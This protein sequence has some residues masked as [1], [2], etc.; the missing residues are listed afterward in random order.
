MESNHLATT[1]LNKAYR[2]TA[3]NREQPPINTLF[4]MCVLKNTK[5]NLVPA[6][7]ATKRNLVPFNITSIFFPQEGMPSTS[8]P[9]CGM[10]KVRHPVLVTGILHTISKS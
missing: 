2:V 10:F 3:G 7:Q 9:V 4:R 1:L 5:R 8:P 6:T